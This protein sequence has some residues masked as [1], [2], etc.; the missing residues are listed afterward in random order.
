[1]LDVT[2]AN[3]RREVQAAE[4]FRDEHIKMLEGMVESYTGLAYDAQDESN[5]PENHAYEYI[6]LT[7]PRVIY[8]NPRVKVKSR[9]AVS[10][11]QLRELEGLLEALDM[12]FQAGMVDPVQGIKDQGLL[13]AEVERLKTL[14][15]TP[16][17]MEHVLNRWSYETNIRKSFQRAYAGMAFAYEVMMTRQEPDPGHDPR[18]YNV[19]HSPKAYVIGADRF[20]FDPL[21][22]IYGEARYAG[23]KWFRDK[24]DLLREAR[25]NNKAGWN[26]KAIRDLAEESAKSTR[27]IKNAPAVDRSEFCGYEIWVPEAN[28]LSEWKVEHPGPDEGFNGSIFTIAYSRAEGR[29]KAS[30]IREPR[31]YYGPTWGP[32]AVFGAY[33]VPGHPYPLAPLAATWAQQKELNAIAKAMNRSARNYKRMIYADRDQ[34]KIIKSGE[35]DFV[36]GVDMLETVE[37]KSV[38]VGGVTRQQV[39]QFTIQ[40]DRIDRVSGISDPQR[41]NISKDDTTATEIAVVDDATNVRLAGV[42]QAFEDAAIQVYRTA[43]WYFWNDERSRQALGDEAAADL[44]MLEPVFYGGPEG[45]MEFDDLELEFEPFSAERTNQAVLQRNANLLAQFVVNT[46]PLIPA[47]PHIDWKKVYGAVGDAYNQ[48]DFGD[49]LSIDKIQ[50]A[51]ALQQPAQPSGGLGKPQSQSAP[52]ETEARSRGQTNQPV[53]GNA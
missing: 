27:D 49:V 4:D 47:S 31:P 2:P 40:R 18:D 45:D 23:H 3:L 44:D 19:P 30:F 12:A 14:K 51:L 9:K 5:A 24:D 8:D 52:Q 29:D 43:S 6:S 50:E 39:E 17:A 28:D 41:G 7:M 11:E 13:E 25:E 46:A 37:P 22:V 20:F 10:S 53:R 42:K 21:C 16:K 34:A 26:V 32:Y 48:R 36:Y 35:H 33:V 1:M 38:E 15:N